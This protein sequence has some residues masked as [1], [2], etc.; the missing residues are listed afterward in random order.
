MGSNAGSEFFGYRAYRT[1]SGGHYMAINRVSS[2]GQREKLEC[3]A[4]L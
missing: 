4:F 3:A 2:R 1:H